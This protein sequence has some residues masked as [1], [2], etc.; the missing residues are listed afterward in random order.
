MRNFQRRTTIMLAAILPLLCGLTG[1]AEMQGQPP[2]ER[3][4]DS[5]SRLYEP[6]SFPHAMHVEIAESCSTC[7]HQ[8]GH[9]AGVPACGN[10]HKLPPAAFKESLNMASMAPCRK[11][12]PDTINVEAPGTPTLQ[13]AY[14]L[15]CLSCHEEADGLK[16][17]PENCT[18]VCHARRMIAAN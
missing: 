3:V 1:R 2:E 10:C 7:H 14:H 11:C 4:L 5:L 16:G 18:A 8:H 12:H 9:I 13:V 17:H 6:V 15:Q